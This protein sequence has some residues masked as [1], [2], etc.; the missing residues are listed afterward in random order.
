MVV[1]MTLSQRPATCSAVPRGV[2]FWFVSL[3]IRSPP[4]STMHSLLL[5]V[6][7]TSAIGCG[8]SRFLEIA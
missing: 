1:A 2:L 4:P 5:G 8:P 6:R 3:W 7:S